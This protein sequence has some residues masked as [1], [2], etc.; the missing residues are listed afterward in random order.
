MPRNDATTATNA[1]R[2][3]KSVRVRAAALRL[4]QACRARFEALEPLHGARLVFR[5][6]AAESGELFGYSQ[7]WG[8]GLTAQ[9]SGAK[10]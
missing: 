9:E 10:A 5:G 8:L 6:Y 4:R 7:P 1:A 3:C 2:A